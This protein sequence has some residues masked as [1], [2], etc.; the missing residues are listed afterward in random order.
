MGHTQ[1]ASSK[2]QAT[3]QTN[4]PG[5]KVMGRADSEESHGEYEDLYHV[6]DSKNKRPISLKVYL[7]GRPR[8]MELDTGSAVSVMSKGVYQE[9][10]HHAP[11]KDTSLKLR[12]YT[13]EP[14]EPMGFCNVTVQYKG[15]SKELPIYVM[16]NE[17]PI[18]FGIEWL[19]SIRLDWPLLQLGTSNVVPVLEEV[20][21]R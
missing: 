13:G 17:G 18:P 6:S 4:D 12:T 7:E 2:K 5:V 8:V 20:L 10:L 1:Q 14:V 19:E 9:Y 11:L 3:H 16:G 21:S 15:Q